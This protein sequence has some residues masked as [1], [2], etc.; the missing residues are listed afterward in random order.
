MLAIEQHEGV[1]VLKGRWDAAQSD[2]AR[3]VFDS[4]HGTAVV[5]CREL[6]YIS[7]SGLGVLLRTQKRLGT[8]G[9]ALKLQHMNGHIR[10]IFRL[11]GF[12]QIFEIE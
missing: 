10:E 2:H 8:A 6:D 5:D 9:H 3:D 12:D 1:V 7:S 4:V 11:C